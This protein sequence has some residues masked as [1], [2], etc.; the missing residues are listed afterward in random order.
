MKK[1]FN[2]TVEHENKT[3][4]LDGNFIVAVSGKDLDDDK[5]M[6]AGTVWGE[7]FSTASV[8]SVLI[9]VFD[10][11]INVLRPAELIVLTNRLKRMADEQFARDT[12]DMDEEELAE[13]KEFAYQL[14]DA[15]TS[16]EYEEGDEI[17][18]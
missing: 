16:F 13:L 7:D 15:T 14:D 4:V 3:E 5:T 2:V 11:S 18:D 17:D 9:S 8:M 1:T 10:R 6:I 12:A